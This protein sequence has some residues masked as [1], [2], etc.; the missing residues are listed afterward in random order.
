M[1]R[2]VFEIPTAAGKIF[3]YMYLSAATAIERRSVDFLTTKEGAIWTWVMGEHPADRTV[4]QIIEVEA[5]AQALRLAEAEFGIHS[6]YGL[7]RVAL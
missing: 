3:V 7:F 4:E 6:G 5:Q 1:Y 2:T